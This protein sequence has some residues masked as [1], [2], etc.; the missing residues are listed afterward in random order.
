MHDTKRTQSNQA[1]RGA[2]LITALLIVTIATAVSIAISTKL[3]LDI[4]RTANMITQDQADFYLY[5]AERW[6][7][8]ILAEDVKDNNTDSLKDNWAVKI[9][10]LPVDGGS[11]QGEITDLHACI[12]INAIYNS[13]GVSQL[14]LNRFKTLLNT[15]EIETDMSQALIDWLDPDADT[16]NP[17]GGEDGYYLNLE[18]PYRTANQHLKSISELRLIKGFEDAKILDR[19][20]PYVCAFD[21]GEVDIPLN[22]NTASAEVLQSISPDLDETIA[23]KALLRRE[24]DPFKDINDFTQYTGIGQL[25]SSQSKLS[26]TSQFFQLRSQAIIGNANKVMYSVIYR[27]SAGKTSIISR[28]MRTL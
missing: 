26:V 28:T 16:T 24:T 25:N 5:A 6:S 1:Q 9:P 7:Q 20:L 8:R 3:Q 23:K 17:D 21:S 13:K 19:L 14:D 2:A 18:K 22:V 27:D 11:I 4:R 15:L 10:P 12:N